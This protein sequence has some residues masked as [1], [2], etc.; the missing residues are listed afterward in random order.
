MFT[1][2]MASTPG[3]RQ[4][5]RMP[6]VPATSNRTRESP[7]V[8]FGFADRLA[9]RVE[10]VAGDQERVRGR[11]RLEDV[12]HLR[13]HRRHVLIVVD[14]R[15]PFAMLVRPHALEALQHFEALDRQ[16]FLLTMAR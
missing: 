5:R 1:T 7:R 8:T 12:P 9:P 2:A 13:R 10:P 3:L 4:L 14:D 6:A 11:I 15:N 16:A